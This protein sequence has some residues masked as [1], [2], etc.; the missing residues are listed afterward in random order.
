MPKQPPRSKKAKRKKSQGQFD[1]TSGVVARNRQ[2]K[3]DYELLD[4][5]ECGIRLT[6]SEIKSIRNGKVV[7]QDAFARVE[8][9]KAGVEEVWLH[10]LDVA[11]Y[12]QASLNNHL[13]KRPRKLLL[14]RREIEK[15]AK[16]AMDK[17]LTL[18]PLDLHFSRGYAKLTLA[19]ARGRKK[20]DNRDRI[21]ADI[22]RREMRQA[23]RK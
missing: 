21:K 9:N 1:Q 4:T 12:P 13:P 14:K 5:L 23:L 3:R 8:P 10:G 16:P 18:V 7:L 2:A 22:D 17:G 15:F 6:G 19:V 20:H 11:E